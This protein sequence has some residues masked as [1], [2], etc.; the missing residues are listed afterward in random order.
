[1]IVDNPLPS[2]SI[3]ATWPQV[4]AV[5]FD[6]DN[7]LW[8]IEPVIVNAER[9]LWAWLSEH[10]PRVTEQHDILSMRE[11][12]QH[13][14]LNFPELGH[15]IAG[16]RRRSLECLLTEFG[17]AD[18]LEEASQRAEAGWRVFYDARHQIEWYDDAHPVLRRLGGHY[19]LA[20]TSNGNADLELLGIA[21][22]FSAVLSAGQVGYAK[23]ESGIWHA[24]CDSLKL[25][26]EQI[27][28][29]GDSVPEDVLGALEHG[30]PAVWLNRNGDDWPD[31][32]PTAAS[33]VSLHQLLP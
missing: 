33:I 32:H 30:L 9:Q 21:D 26:P 5:S 10:H 31:A 11:H 7:T 13:T 17:Y 28:H 1:M 29:I 25:S 2:I 16:L 22:H 8:P 19:R 24:L 18:S 6:L 12:R 27:L 23:P 20:A 15:D 4:R 3:A 14:A